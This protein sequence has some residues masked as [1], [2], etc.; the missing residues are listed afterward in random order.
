MVR[1]PG[2]A[3]RAR[4]LAVLAVL[5]SQDEEFRE[6]SKAL[7]YKREDERRGELERIRK[8]LNLPETA[9]AEGYLTGL[10]QYF[11]D[12]PRVRMLVS[13][14]RPVHELL[15]DRDGVHLPLEVDPD[16]CSRWEPVGTALVDSQWTLRPAERPIPTLAD[17]ER[18]SGAPRWARGAWADRGL[19]KGRQPTETL[20]RDVVLFFL[21]RWRG[22]SPLEAALD[23]DELASAGRVQHRAKRGHRRLPDG[24]RAFAGELLTRA[25]VRMAV[26]HIDELFTDLPST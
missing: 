19:P 17:L 23:I 1:I 16:A 4:A 24:E 15:L 13:H 21:L 2:P 12:T 3:K 25:T 11:D 6:R 14:A 10:V 8:R 5:M 7:R 26:Q 9:W 18:R 22:M 20:R